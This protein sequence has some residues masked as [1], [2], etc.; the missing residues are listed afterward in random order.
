MNVSGTPTNRPKDERLIPDSR[1]LGMASSAL[2][3][4]GRGARSYIVADTAHPHDVP[5][6]NE[7]SSLNGSSRLMTSYF[8]K[9]AGI[10]FMNERYRF[11]IFRQ[12]SC[13]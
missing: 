11:K 3:K 10:L 8:H 2:F 4:S 13:M 5:P 1:G 9:K 7:G 12:I 6:H